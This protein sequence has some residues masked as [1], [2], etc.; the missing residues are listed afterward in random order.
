MSFERS[1]RRTVSF[2]YFLTAVLAPCSSWAG[3][4]AKL[5]ALDGA[6]EDR[7]GYSVSASGD[8]VVVGAHLDDDDGRDSGRRVLAVRQ[9]DAVVSDAGVHRR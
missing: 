8:T 2:L 1:A 3:E 4:Q 7:F 5:A 6:A 9:R